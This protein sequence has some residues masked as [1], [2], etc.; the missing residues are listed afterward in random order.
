MGYEAWRAKYWGVLKLLYQSF[1]R[2]SGEK[3]AFETFCQQL[4]METAW[5]EPV[6]DQGRAA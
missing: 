6:Q 4:Y 3:V 2:N 5:V 1:T